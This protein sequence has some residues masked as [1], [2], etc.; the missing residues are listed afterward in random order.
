MAPAYRLDRAE[1]AAG[2]AR[3]AGV[4]R[5]VD[6]A[7]AHLIALLEAGRGEGRAVITPGA[8]GLRVFAINQTRNR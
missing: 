7:G 2:I 3:Q 6:V 8:V 5:R 4:R 1:L